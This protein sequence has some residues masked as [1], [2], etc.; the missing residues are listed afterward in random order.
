[1]L[2]AFAS[3]LIQI[4]E[5]MDIVRA[6]AEAKKLAGQIGFGLGDQTRLATAV[7][8]LARNVL[9]Y[10]GEGQCQ[11]SDIS[12]TT[13]LGVRIAVE[14]HGPGIPDITRAMQDGFST[15]GGLGAGLPGTQRLMDSFH[16][17][18]CPQG[19][20]VTVSMVRRRV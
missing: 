11:I 10:A 20:K 3:Q 12:S 7:S 18:S 1:M 19:T 4:R 2:A 5:Q 16:I 9:Q 6:R 8:E 17:E 13:E 15:S 14:D